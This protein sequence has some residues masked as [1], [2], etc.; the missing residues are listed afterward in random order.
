[1]KAKALDTVIA[2]YVSKGALVELPEAPGPGFYSRVPQ[3]HTILRA[4]QHVDVYLKP[5]LSVLIITVKVVCTLV[6]GKAS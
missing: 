6:T 3:T 1:M 5:V 4:V 2:D